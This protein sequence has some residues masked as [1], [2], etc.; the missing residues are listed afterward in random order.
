MKQN[1]IDFQIGERVFFKTGKIET[2]AVFLEDNKD[3]TCSVIAHFIGGQVANG[4]ELRVLKNKLKL[5]W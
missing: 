5:H 2:K 1:C 4:R 3:G